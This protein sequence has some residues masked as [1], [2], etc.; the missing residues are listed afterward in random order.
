M[1]V[2]KK[3]SKWATVHCHG[4]DKGKVISTFD[5]K[6]KAM[7]QH[8]AIMANKKKQKHHSAPDGDFLQKRMEA[9]GL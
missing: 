1:T 6:K 4:S 7:A 3:G 5:T 8:R 2:K 9:H